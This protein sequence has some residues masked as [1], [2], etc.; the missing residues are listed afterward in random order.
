MWLGA[1]ELD[2]CHRI[3]RASVSSILMILAYQLRISEQQHPA[4]I[5]D[6]GGGG[7]GGPNLPLFNISWFGWYKNYCISQ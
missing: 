5:L 2:T 3:H 4:D 7:G 6:W 1:S